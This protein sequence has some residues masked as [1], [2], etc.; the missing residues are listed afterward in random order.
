[1]KTLRNHKSIHHRRI[2]A[3]L[4]GMLLLLMPILSGCLP[5][6]GAGGELSKLAKTVEAVQTDI[7]PELNTL[8][9]WQVT[10]VEEMLALKEE[11]KARGEI[12]QA[13]QY[14]EEIAAYREMCE[15]YLETVR[16][17]KESA[18]AFTTLPDSTY[19]AGVEYFTR[20]EESIE[21]LISIMVFDKA[22]EEATEPVTAFSSRS[23]TDEWSKISA[24][25]EALGIAVTNLRGVDCPSYMQQLY[26][27]YVD[28]CQLYVSF[29]EQWVNDISL[30]DN[31]RYAAANNMY[32]RT[33]LYEDRYGVALTKD[34]CLQY[35]KT[36]TRLNGSIQTLA[37]ELIGA[38]KLGKAELEA[39]EYTYQKSPYDV[40]ISFESANTI[41]PSLYGSMDSIL[42]FTATSDNGSLD[43]LVETEIPG[44]TQKYSQTFTITPQMTKFF[45]KPPLMT[46]ELDLSSAKDAQV[47]FSVTTAKG[48]DVLAKHS[49]PVRIMSKY[50]IEYW[51]DD[52][53]MATR[54]NYLCFLTPEATSIVE[55]K[56]LAIDC[57]DDITNGVM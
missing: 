34:F 54:D 12:Y 22:V 8:I 27:R 51:N 20:M 38:Q 43:I 24:L 10:T 4:L 46:G 16:G 19:A 9:D 55:L 35:E 21:S 17:Y 33:M 25:Y 13:P 1:M 26:G 50:D 52:F 2:T 57:L 39:F 47:T 36:G 30:G 5:T 31:L 6:F 44:F 28:T 49:V 37:N 15:G 41:Y 18:E 11:Y 56:R 14:E 45:I 29:V 48:G 40:D 23:F 32:Q 42:N 53:G 7:V 3:L